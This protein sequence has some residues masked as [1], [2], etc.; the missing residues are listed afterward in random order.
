V[1]ELR[2]EALI[3]HERSKDRLRV[4][5]GKGHAIDESM[6]Q[7]ALRLGAK[8]FTSTKTRGASCGVRT[9]GHKTGRADHRRDTAALL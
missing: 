6:L 1:L 4:L 2:G 9:P 8:C 7:E 3:K 5:G